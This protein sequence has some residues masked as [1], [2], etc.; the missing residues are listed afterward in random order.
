MAVETT[1]EYNK[2]KLNELIVEGS[3]DFEDWTKLISYV[4]QLYHLNS[5]SE[6]EIAALSLDG[7][8]WDDKFVSYFLQDEVD[9]ITWV[10]DS[11]LSEFPLCYGYWKKYAERKARLCSVEKAVEIFERAVESVPYS[12]GVW[13]DYCSFSVSSFENPLEICR[14]GDIY[15]LIPGAVRCL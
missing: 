11:F 14:S 10:Y 5:S 4:E 9:K 2:L 8:S 6:L 3:L 1:E 15:C 7:H 13:V 12:V